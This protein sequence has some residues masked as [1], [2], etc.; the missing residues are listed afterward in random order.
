MSQTISWSF[1]AQVSNGPSA[2][3][4][5]KMT[6]DAY[7]ALTATVPAGGNVTVAVQPGDGCQL[8]VITAGEY[9]GISYTVD[10]G[11]AITL[12]GAH[13]LIGS[14]AATLLGA[15]QNS[16]AFTNAGAADV[17]VSILVGRNATS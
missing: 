6:V 8:L 9:A 14:G 3:A 12:D 17:N 15:T 2:S 7:D 11:S 4:S 10:G 5:G 16:F 1:Q 13:A